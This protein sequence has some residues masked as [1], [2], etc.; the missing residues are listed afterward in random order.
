MESYSL[1]AVNM[2]GVATGYPLLFGPTIPMW[3]A[4]KRMHQNFDGVELSAIL[5][6]STFETVWHYSDP[7][8]SHMAKLRKAMSN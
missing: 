2:Q 4:I 1:I 5:N 3:Y 8:G 6:A 7:D